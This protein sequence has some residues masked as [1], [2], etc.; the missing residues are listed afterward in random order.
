MKVELT[1]ASDLKRIKL[2]C[3]LAWIKIYSLIRKSPSDFQSIITRE[4]LI[5]YTRAHIYKYKARQIAFFAHICDREKYTTLYTPYIGIPYLN[6]TGE[7]GFSRKWEDRDYEEVDR[8]QWKEM[9]WHAVEWRNSER[10][11]DTVM[12]LSAHRLPSPDDIAKNVE[13]SQKRSA[14]SPER[15]TFAVMIS[16]TSARFCIARL[17]SSELSSCISSRTR[18]L[19]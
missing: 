12:F 15:I 18:E 16:E 9:E 5:T 2:C 6:I 4:L 19:A 14:R 11:T 10:I 3:I 8:R 17:I 1:C 13:T 7:N